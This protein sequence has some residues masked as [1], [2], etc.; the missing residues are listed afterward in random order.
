MYSPNDPVIKTNGDVFIQSYQGASLHIWAT[1]RVRISDDVWIT[2]AD[3]INGLADNVA[4]SNGTS[5][6][7]DGRGEPTLDIRAGMTLAGLGTPTTITDGGIF[8]AFVPISPPTS[9]DIEVGSI[10]FANS[11][12]FTDLLPGK[13][14]LT[15]QYEPNASLAGNITV[16]DTQGLGT[17]QIGG[18]IDTRSVTFDSKGEITLNGN[19][20][21]SSPNGMGGEVTLLANS[22]IVGSSINTSG[23]ING[24]SGNIAL[25]S[26]NG[27]IFLSNAFITSENRGELKGGDIDIRGRSLFVNDGTQL[28]T[29]NFGK[30][31]AGN[32]TIESFKQVTL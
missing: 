32:V 25:I 19:I 16:T 22:N 8:T 13:V 5:I 18:D 28:S 24:S 11:A 6:A 26:Q 20:N 17:I 1:G 30:G 7:I 27:D 29:I 31:D 12:D 14:L 2:G 21:V 10:L 15:N 23:G 9:A 4:L 3:T